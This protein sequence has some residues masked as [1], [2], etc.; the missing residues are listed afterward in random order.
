MTSSAGSKSQNAPTWALICPNDVTVDCD[1]ELWDLSI[2]GNAQY[3]NSTGYH[4]AGTPVTNYYLNSCGSGYITRTW[5]L[6]DPYWNLQSCTQTITVGG[7]WVIST[8]QPSSGLPWF[9]LE[10][11]NPNTHPD[12]T[13]KPTW[14]PVECAII[15]YS[16]TD[17]LYTVTPDCK[18]YLENGRSSTGAKCPR[19]A[20]TATRVVGPLRKPSRLSIRYL[21]IFSVF[22]ILR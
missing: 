3:H 17:A 10:G 7:R 20:T 13:G 6:E 8:D 1:A 5:T 21:P 16:Y 11:C 15:G 12:V 14:V 4:S 19:V 18:R 9:N 22:L 2:Y